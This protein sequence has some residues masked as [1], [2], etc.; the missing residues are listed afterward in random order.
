MDTLSTCVLSSSRVS[1]LCSQAANACSDKQVE[2]HEL[3][4]HDLHLLS[5]PLQAEAPL[6]YLFIFIRLYKN[7]ACIIKA[8]TDGFWK[9]PR[10]PRSKNN[11]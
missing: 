8:C 5:G 1:A 11:H 6:S 10:I 2:T 3:L 9:L 7:E 4:E